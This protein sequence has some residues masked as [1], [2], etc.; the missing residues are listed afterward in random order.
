MRTQTPERGRRARLA[1]PGALIIGAQKSGTSA[2]AA[3]LAQHPRVLLAKQKELEFFGSDLRYGY[4]LDWY[5][6]QWPDGS[7]RLIRLE[8]SPQYMIV[9]R[10]AARIRCD[11]PEVR[12]IALVRDPAERA[13]SAWQMYR[14]Q[15]A[16]DPLFYRKLIGAHYTA[17]EAAAL[18]RRTA[19]ELD[20]FWLAVRREAFCIERGETMEWSVV[21]LGLYGPQ[22]QR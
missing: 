1:L 7:R 2:L 4:G 16:E 11:L 8:A 20:D 19:E 3:Y 18:V 9:P 17:E 10:A 12:L 15:L 22:L 13:Y 14:R 21:E 5:A 6:D